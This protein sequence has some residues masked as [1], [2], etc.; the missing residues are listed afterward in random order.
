M[1]LFIV[2]NGLGAKDVLVDGPNGPTVEDDYRIDYLKQ[3]L[4]QVGEAIEDGV[5]LWG[6]TTWGC[7]DLVSASTAQMSKRYGFI[8]VD[9]NDDGTG[10]LDRYKKNHLIGI[11]KLLQRT[12][13]NSMKIE[14]TAL[15]VR[16]LE[17]AKRF[18]ETY[19][20][21]KSNQLYYNQKTGFQSYFLSFDEGAR[22]EIM[23]RKEGL[24]DN[25][26]PL[27]FAS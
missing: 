18:F 15:Y 27:H 11:K 26:Q 19:F 8:Y 5:E 14:H 12:E 24:A 2:E 3:H 6:Y 21:A 20:E 17:G 25:N 13:K 4:Q 22:L 7:I 23:T 10:S 1:P 9:R 16:D